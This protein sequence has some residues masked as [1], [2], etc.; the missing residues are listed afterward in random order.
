MSKTVSLEYKDLYLEL[1]EFCRQ[2]C[3]CSFDEALPIFQKKLWELADKCGVDG[4]SFFIMWM[5]YNSANN[6][7][8]GG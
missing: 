7:K 4:S 1:N 8:I 3:K 5:N 6:I 2:N